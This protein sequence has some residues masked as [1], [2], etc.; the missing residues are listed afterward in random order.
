MNPFNM[1]SI[2]YIV[3][4]FPVGYLIDTIMIGGRLNV[5]YNSRLS[6]LN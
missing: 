2:T 5:C 6:D 4:P 3:K 1:T